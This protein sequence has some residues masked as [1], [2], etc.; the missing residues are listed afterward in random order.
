MFGSGC[1][2]AGGRIGIGAGCGCDSRPDF[3]AMLKPFMAF[4][5]PGFALDNNP[6]KRANGLAVAPS[7]AAPGIPRP[8]AVSPAT[9]APN[10]EA[11]PPPIP[12]A[13]ASS[14]IPVDNA[15]GVATSSAAVLAI[16]GPNRD[17]VPAPMPAAGRLAAAVPPSSPVPAPA[18]PPAAAA[19]AG[20]IAAAAVP[21]VAA[22][23]AAKAAAMAQSFLWKLCPPM[24][25]ASSPCR[26]P[27]LPIASLR[28]LSTVKHPA[29]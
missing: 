3:C 6:C 12:P 26:R 1:C 5:I 23:A 27:C 15:I 25:M 9:G 10:S 11:V 7:A 24:L 19:S 18:T 28:Q 29:W 22:A 4:F 21:P 20:T 8:S 13:A 16:V 17:A 2:G 14:G